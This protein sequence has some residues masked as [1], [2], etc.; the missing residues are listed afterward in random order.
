MDTNDRQAIDALF[1]KLADVERQV[2]T[3]DAEAERFIADSVQRQPAA[4]YYMAQTVIVQEQ[5]LEAAQRRI[6]ELESA[7]AASSSSNAGG[8][9][10][11]LFGGSRPSAR[12]AGAVPRT[13]SVPRPSATAGGKWGSGSS[14]AYQGRPGFGGGSGGGFL[15]GAAQTAMG[16]AGGVLLGNAIAGMFG[17]DEAQAAEAAAPAE[18]AGVEDAAVEDAGFDDGGDFGDI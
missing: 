16:V 6:E 7:S 18:D 13:G 14:N 4:A 5:A 11:G 1:N 9:F 3:R 17:G 2:P 15:A 10:G 12:P 8:L